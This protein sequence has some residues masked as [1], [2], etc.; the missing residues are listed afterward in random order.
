[1]NLGTLIYKGC[2]KE[3]VI[4]GTEGIGTGV[5]EYFD[6]SWNSNI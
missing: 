6:V 1:M 2:Q 4:K 3:V 5:D